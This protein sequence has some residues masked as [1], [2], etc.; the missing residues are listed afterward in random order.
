[1]FR[2]QK[3][4][5]ATAVSAPRK[6]Q[7]QPGGVAP[8]GPAGTHVNHP[9]AG[10][11]P[12][13]RGSLSMRFLL[14]STGLGTLAVVL[15]TSAAA[16]TVISTATTTLCEERRR[17][18]HPGRQQLGGDRR[19]PGARRRH[20]Q[21]RHDHHRRELHAERVGERQRSEKLE[22]GW[23]LDE[24]QDAIVPPGWVKAPDEGAKEPGPQEPSG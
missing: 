22:Q 16:E 8:H 24:E 20:H 23:T 5:T 18:R 7:P 14:A 11:S 12:D 10:A 3:T 19:Q 13:N 1:L 15:A 21:H 9:A 2:E 6:A 17:H 4:E